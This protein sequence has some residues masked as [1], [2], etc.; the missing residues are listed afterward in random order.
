MDACK[1]SKSGQTLVAI[2]KKFLNL[3]FNDAVLYR[4]YNEEGIRADGTVK[5]RGHLRELLFNKLI[6]NYLD[7]DFRKLCNDPF[8]SDPDEKLCIIVDINSPNYDISVNDI[9]RHCKPCL[10]EARRRRC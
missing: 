3:D 9:N 5:R 10:E 6:A 8:I 4:V 2:V 7:S 1:D